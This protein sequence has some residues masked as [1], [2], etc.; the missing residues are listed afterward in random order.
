MTKKKSILAVKNLRVGFE[1]DYKSLLEGVEFEIHEGEKLGICGESGCGKSLS[2]LSLIQLLPSNAKSSGEIL[3]D[4]GEGAENLMS[5]SEPEWRKIRGKDIAMVFQNAQQALN[6]LQR[7]GKQVEECLR[8]HQPQMQRAERQARVLEI[9]KRVELENPEGVMQAFP[10]ELSGGMRQRVLIAMS[11]VNHPMLL[12]ADE[13]TTALDISV[14]ERILELLERFNDEDRLAILLISHDLRIVRR[15]CDRALIYYAGEIVEEGPVE[16]VFG[17]PGHVYTKLLLEAMPEKANPMEELTE[18]PGRVPSSQ[19]IQKH[20]EAQ[21]PPCIFADR[22]PHRKPECLEGSPERVEISPGHFARCVLAK[23]SKA[24]ESTREERK[25]RSKRANFD[26]LNGTSVRSAGSG[27]AKDKATLD[28]KF[29]KMPTPYLMVED[30]CH[31]FP[32]RRR[33]EARHQVLKDVDFRIFPGQFMGLVGASGSG[34]STLAKLITGQLK[35]QGGHI[36]LNGR[37]ISGLSPRERRKAKLGMQMV[38]QDPYSSLHPLQSVGRQLEEPLR[39][40]TKFNQEE[41]REKVWQILEDV[42]LDPG[43]ASRKPRELSGGQLQRVAIGCALITKPKLLIV[44]EPTSA[45]DLSVQAQILNLFG[46]LRRRLDFACLF[47]S[48][49]MDVIRYLCDRVAVLHE[50]EIVEEDKVSRVFA[51]PKHPYTAALLEQSL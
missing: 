51:N 32:P 18:I 9:F 47:I 35:T 7:V 31:S 27:K 12:L 13:P 42:G 24:V 48:H 21:N 16:E 50:G 33:G 1:P 39:I 10:H 38:F 43:L 44:D 23:P 25:T 3:L 36:Y 11:L 46:Q 20:H 37:E 4:S 19:E 26:S 28:E 30:V 41:R 22:C 17:N 40:H 5:K 8:I 14:Q 15:F 34:K 6:P 29:A 2:A 49:D 45:L